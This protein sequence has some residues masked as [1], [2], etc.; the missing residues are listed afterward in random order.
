[1][2]SSATNDYICSANVNGA[3]ESKK[4]GTRHDLKVCACYVLV[5]AK[6]I[7][8]HK[9]STNPEVEV[10]LITKAYQAIKMSVT[11]DM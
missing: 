3:D 9:C 4:H 1:M 7:C 2:T 8:K 10:E 11:R 6:Y 5:C